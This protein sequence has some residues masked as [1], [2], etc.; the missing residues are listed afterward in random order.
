[1]IALVVGRMGQWAM[2]VGV[3]QLTLSEEKG[4]RFAD[5]LRHLHWHLK[6]LRQNNVAHA[7]LLDDTLPDAMVAEHLLSCSVILSKLG[8]ESSLIGLDI[9]HNEL[10]SIQQDIRLTLISL[11]DDNNIVSSDS[12]GAAVLGHQ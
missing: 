11:E 2:G 10:E 3:Q 8:F 9:D 6:Q 5:H 7:L 4:F 12:L 1:M